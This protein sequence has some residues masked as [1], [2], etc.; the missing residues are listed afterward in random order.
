[1]IE[2]MEYY[3]NNLEKAKQLLAELKDYYMNS[4][5]YLESYYYEAFKNNYF[6]EL[7]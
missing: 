4:E 3:E 6:K 2:K 5:F 1:M 7:Y